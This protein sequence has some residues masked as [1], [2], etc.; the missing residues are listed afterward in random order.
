VW[1]RVV[2]VATKSTALSFGTVLG[3]YLFGLGLGTFV[4]VQGAERLRRPLHTFLLLQCLLVVYAAAAMLFLVRAPVWGDLSRW[5]HAYWGQYDEFVP[6][7]DRDLGGLVRLY[8]FVPFALFGMPTTLMGLSFVALQR[9]VQNDPSTS[10]RKVGVLQ[11]ANIAGCVLGSLGVGLVLLN[12]LG[13]L[14]TLRL[15]VVC[16]LVFAAVGVRRFGVRSSFGLLGVALVSLAFSL[17][18]R[19]ALWLRL[20]GRSGGPAVLTEDSTGVVLIAREGGGPRWQVSVNGRGI[21]SLPFGGMHSELGAVPALMHPS[22][23]QVAI[24]GLGSG[25]TAWAASCRDETRR[26]TVFEIV[27]PQLPLLQEAGSLADWPDLRAFLADRRIIVRIADARRALERE[28][29]RYDVIEGDPLEPHSAYSG[30]LYSVEF[31]RICASRLRQRGLMCS[32]APSARTRATFLAAFPHVLEFRGGEFLVGSNEAVVIDLPSWLG[33]LQAASGYLGASI[34]TQ[35][36]ASLE[37]VR[38][39]DRLEQAES[40]I[41]RDLFPRDEFLTP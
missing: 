22:P 1:F 21:S 9:A 20:H 11:A 38:T 34:A 15:I 10:G 6:G 3:V 14:G 41:N 26:T 33:R 4:G 27:G 31:F 7:L 35:V 24:V 8:A 17:P 30:N 25:D 13:S 28:G 37:S 5:L 16:A 2:D 32:Y 19:E 23:H 29:S 36:A 39:V 40:A 12:W 18:A